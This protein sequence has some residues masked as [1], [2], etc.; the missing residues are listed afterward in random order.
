MFASL[1]AGHPKKMILRLSVVFLLLAGGVMAV[2]YTLNMS[3]RAQA[4]Y[5]QMLERADKRAQDK[6]GTF[7]Q[8][9]AE[10]KRTAAS[11]TS[12]NLVRIFLAEGNGAQTPDPQ[13]SYIEHAL[14]DMQKRL[15]GRG[16]LLLTPQGEALLASDSAAFL[17][18]PQTSIPRLLEAA[19]SREPLFG[20]MFKAGG[21]IYLEVFRP[22]F[23]LAEEKA[24]QVVGVLY[25]QVSID[26]VQKAFADPLTP[27][28]KTFF[29]AKNAQ[30][31]WQA[32]SSAE[33]TLLSK[34]D[35]TQTGVV[36][37][38][39]QSKAIQ[40]VYM[41][42]SQRH[43][44][45]HQT[46]YTWA[47]ADYNA[48]AQVYMWLLAAVVV[49]LGAVFTGLLWYGLTKRD[50]RRVQHLGQMVEAFM[51]A[52]EARDPYLSGHHERVARLALEIG[53]AYGLPIKDRAALFYS[54]K[55]SGIGRMYIPQ[56]ILSKKGKLTKKERQAVE[57][58]VRHTLDVLD[59]IE[60][61][62]PVEETILQMHERGDGSGYPNGLTL[63]D[64]DIKAQIL[65]LCDTYC[66]L[67]NPR[68][69]RDAFTH[70][71][72]VKEIAS[73]NEQFRPALIS[74]L[75]KK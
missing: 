21:G 40:G 14:G 68:A 70:A 6:A 49:A 31:V 22:I 69:Y 58:H 42:P 26:E 16:A 56:E 65:G 5:Q 51:R 53:N 37:N 73:K 72:A 64:I 28:D 43:G 63:A 4:Q 60:F 35:P 34:I 38:L 24:Q 30:G 7:D 8:W 9:R 20:E 61:D 75:K 62:L 25:L 1:M 50:R 57:S 19:Q 10:I 33:N 13:A 44:V 17:T 41:L 12:A 45:V 27:Y 48:Y 36:Q 66:A 23:N 2:L 39:E 3:N 32:V 55:L 54:A 18:L 74:L 11:F 46:D 15:R 71:K 52:I 59:G 29:A 47:M 67:T